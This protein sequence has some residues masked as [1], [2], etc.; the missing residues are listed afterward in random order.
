LWQLSVWFYR[1]TYS[2]PLGALKS[3][4]SISN[5]LEKHIH[6]NLWI[7]IIGPIEDRW[8]A[9]TTFH[10]DFVDFKLIREDKSITG[11]DTNWRTGEVTK[12][13]MNGS[14]YKF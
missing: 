12:G 13:G 14:H 10:V 7:W 4:N 3:P 1:I 8:L 11:S 2:P 9:N 6:V 5:T